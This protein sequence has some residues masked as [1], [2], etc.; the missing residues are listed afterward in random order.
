MQD[1]SNATSVPRKSD[2][3]TQFLYDLRFGKFGER[4]SRKLQSIGDRDVIE[5]CASGC[6]VAF[7]LETDEIFVDLLIS[8]CSN[9]TVERLLFFFHVYFTH[10]PG[11][12]D[13]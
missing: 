9:G 2:P 1:K 4:S 13:A 7:F 3:N 12:C 10:P 8:S 6:E 5:P 11:R